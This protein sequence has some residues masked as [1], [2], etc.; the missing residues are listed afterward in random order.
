MKY[1]ATL[2]SISE[3]SQQLDLNDS[4]VDTPRKKQRVKR[5]KT[6]DGDSIPE[7]RLPAIGK[8]MTLDE[9]KA[10]IYDGNESFNLLWLLSKACVKWEK[11]TYIEFNRM[12]QFIHQGMRKNGFGI[13]WIKKY[14]LR[15]VETLGNETPFQF[16][17]KMTEKY[18]PVDESNFHKQNAFVVTQRGK[19]LYFTHHTPSP[20]MSPMRGGDTHSS[21]IGLSSPT[22]L[23]LSNPINFGATLPNSGAMPSKAHFKVSPPQGI[24]LEQYCWVLVNQNQILRNDRDLTCKLLEKYR[25]VNAMDDQPTLVNSLNELHTESDTLLSSIHSLNE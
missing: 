19:E 21:L 11:H 18:P 12:N 2:S 15:L 5:D 4:M 7:P 24:T 9:M 13:R 23:M 17:D 16:W 14:I 25:A 10:P 3:V 8:P 1:T 22:M 20:M 6:E